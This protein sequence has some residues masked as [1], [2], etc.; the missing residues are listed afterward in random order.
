[1][2]MEHAKGME[3]LQKIIKYG[4]NIDKNWKKILMGIRNHHKHIVPF[5]KKPPFDFQF[6]FRRGEGAF[7]VCVTYFWCQLRA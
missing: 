6:T 2:E 7:L 5:F 1:M 3:K 4:K